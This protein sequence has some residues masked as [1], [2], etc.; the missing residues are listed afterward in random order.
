MR[1]RARPSA[2]ITV[3][4]AP[5]CHLCDEAKATL[6]ELSKD[7]PIVVEIVDATSPDGRALVARHRPA[8][9]PLVLLDGE[10]FSSGRLPRRKLERTLT[11]LGA[12]VPAVR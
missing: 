8:L 2:Q 7:H 9:A 5:A 3:V 1:D 6:V 10:F 11:A 12:R 4:E